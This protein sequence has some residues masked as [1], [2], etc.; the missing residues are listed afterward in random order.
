[1]ILAVDTETTGVDFSH[2][3]RPFFVTT[4][5]GKG[6][7]KSWEWW[8]DP[9]TRQPEIPTEDVAAID[10]L[11]RSAATLVLQGPKF[12]VR[13]L[14]EIGITDWPWERTKCTLR[15]G[16]L[17]KSNHPHNLTDMV[18]EYL[19]EDIL[20]LEVRLR[21]ACVKARA[22]ARREYPDWRIAKDGL[23]EMPSAKGGSSDKDKL[24]K[25][26]TWLPRLLARETQLPEPSADCEHL[27][28]KTDNLCNKCGGHLWWVV[29]AEYANADSP[30]TLA[31]WQVMEAEIAKRGLEAIYREVLRVLPIAY[32]MEK[33]GVTINRVKQVELRQEFLEE[34]ERLGRVC[35]NIAASFD[36]DL[37]LPKSGNNK[38][39]LTAAELLLD[40]A[41][42]YVEKSLSEAGGL[43]LNKVSLESYLAQVE[44]NSKAYLF[45]D[46]LR[47]KR[48]RNTAIQYLDGYERFWLPLGV[49]NEDGEQAWYCLYPNLNP[50]GTDTLR[51]SSAQPNSQNISKKESF[52]LRRCFG[53]APGREWWSLD[54]KN[55]ELR[56]PAYVSGEAELIALFE[57]PDEPPYYGST[58][59]LNF[60]TVY[61]DLWNKE[62]KIVGLEKVGPL[63]K[64]KYAATWYQWCK[65]GGFAIQYGA[66]VET[67]DRAFH[68]DGSHASLKTRFARLEN[69]NQK[70]I[71][72]A[73]RKGYVET[74][75]DRSVDPSRGYPLLCTRSERGGIVPTV[76]LNYMVQGSAMWWTMRA[77]TR[78]DEKL[79]EWRVKDGFDGRIVMQ[80]HD[81][82]VMDFPK[83]GDPTKDKGA[84]KTSNLWR[85][86]TIQRLM[87]Q[88]G[89]DLGVPTPTG[90]E[91][92]DSSWADGVTL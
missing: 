54:A 25:N 70:C 47:S 19:G 44:R 16:H 39:L 42:T 75:P 2:G 88:G 59:L 10:A 11:I 6:V 81:E 84:F 36:V 61:P 79:R 73:G 20:P 64:K 85:I 62:L 87:E 74:L 82:L 43:S 83:R 68:C 72:E 34:S 38:S 7:I 92:H 71:R 56:I 21:D 86:R 78:T 50:T 32:D 55:I 22:Q 1:M 69:L 52:N 15:A 90:C 67:A 48:S 35:V 14:A 9:L 23:P 3:T 4:C 91:Y 51:W 30:Y 58:H 76:P 17:L 8:V 24:W 12:D 60:H 33:Q 40:Q 41:G 65:N 18:M 27:W 45:F 13:A 28:D 49:Y 80:V 77:M 26:D 53:P 31:L 37:T 66:G 57:R 89:L 46:S 29:L 5:D 63:V